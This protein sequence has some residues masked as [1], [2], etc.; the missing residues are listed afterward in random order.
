MLAKN[1]NDNAALL[2]TR[3]VDSFFASMLAPTE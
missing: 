2:F 1:A 3:V